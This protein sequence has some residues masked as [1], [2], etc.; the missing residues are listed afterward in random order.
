MTIQ[1]E[2]QIAV[3]MMNG[4]DDRPEVEPRV[5]LAHSAAIAAASWSTASPVL[6]PAGHQPDFAR[7]PVVEIEA[8]RAQRCGFL[9]A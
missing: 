1:V 6:V 9:G 4:S 2:P 7:A 3:K 8:L 5:L